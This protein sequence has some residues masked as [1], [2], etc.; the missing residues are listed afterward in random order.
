MVADILAVGGAPWDVCFGV[1][2]GLV[3][4]DV[5]FDDLVL[6]VVEAGLGGP[7]RASGRSGEVSRE[8]KDEDREVDVCV[9]GCEGG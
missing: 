2:D 9:A 5:V 4:C 1:R 6:P 8:G 7:E 3:S